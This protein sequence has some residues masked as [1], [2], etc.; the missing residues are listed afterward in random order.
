LIAIF[1]VFLKLVRKL[2]KRGNNFDEQLRHDAAVFTLGITGLFFSSTAYT[3]LIRPIVVLINNT[4]DLGNYIV[5]NADKEKIENLFDLH[6]LGEAFSSYFVRFPI[7]SFLF[8]LAFF[9]LVYQGIIYLSFS[10]FQQPIAQPAVQNIP[11]HK[12]AVA[13]NT[14]VIFILAFSLFLVLSVFISIPYLNQINKPSLFT[15]NRLD[16]LLT[17]IRLSDTTIEKRQFGPSPFISKPI[18]DTLILRDSTAIKNYSKLKTDARNTIDNVM[19]DIDESNAR[20]ES[21]RNGQ[22]SEVQ[23]RIQQFQREK[24]TNQ[25]KL[26][27][28]YERV[29]QSN[30]VNKDLQFETSVESYRSYVR[31]VNETMLWIF[32]N[33]LESDDYNA[34]ENVRVADRIRSAITLFAQNPDSAAFQDLYFPPPQFLQYNAIPLQTAVGANVSVGVNLRDGSE[35]GFFGLIARYLIKTES[36]ELVLL[37]GMLGFGLFGASISSF[38]KGENFSKSFATTPIIKDFWSVLIRGFSAALLIYLATKGGI[39]I[40]TAGSNSDPNGYVL[41]LLCFIAAVFSE[42]IWEKAK[43]KFGL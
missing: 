30:I 32:T 36:L 5:Q 43:A 24:I 33:F 26:I 22:I 35:W 23:R 4:N 18:G 12:R 14:A 34:K 41:L 8:A 9:A 28:D 37:I 19:R 39:S 13:Y 3:V 31:A 7:G 2:F 40:I 17:S 16:T 6:S 1:I 29:T 11:A 21:R 10:A 27:L 38:N 25:Q 20:E 15:K 42:K